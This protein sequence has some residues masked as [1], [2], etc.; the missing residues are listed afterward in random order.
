MSLFLWCMSFFFCWCLDIEGV[1]SSVVFSLLCC[2]GER[3]GGEG[4]G[5]FIYF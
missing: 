3:G 1:V 2:K 4:G 5:R